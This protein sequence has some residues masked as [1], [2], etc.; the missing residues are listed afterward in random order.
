MAI[1]PSTEGSSTGDSSKENKENSQIESEK[2]TSAMDVDAT[3]L[4]SSPPAIASAPAPAPAST[5]TSTSTSTSISA[6]AVA[7][8]ST[9]DQTQSP[10]IIT[11]SA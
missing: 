8:T 5:A 10:V 3:N 11:A 4:V 2:S 1:N 6:P 7:T 9:Q